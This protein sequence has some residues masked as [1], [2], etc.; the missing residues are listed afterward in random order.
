MR[1]ELHDPHRQAVRVGIVL[2]VVCHPLLHEIRRPG[3]VGRPVWEVRANIAEHR[4]RRRRCN[5]AAGTCFRRR[6]TQAIDD[7]RRTAHARCRLPDARQ[8]GLAICGFRCRGVQIRLAVECLGNTGRW[9]A[10]PLCRQV[11]RDQSQGDG[12]H[13]GCQ[14][15][16]DYGWLLL[17]SRG[18]T[19]REFPPPP[20][21]VLWFTAQLFIGYEHAPMVGRNP[22]LE[23]QRYAL[24]PTTSRAGSLLIVD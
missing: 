23:Q 19:H 9:I 2:A 22:A 7:R 21:P 12:Q 20:R 10:R 14:R 6:G 11:G 17:E 16:P 18:S 24:R 15:P 1:V 13:R 8:I 4:S 3:L 5:R